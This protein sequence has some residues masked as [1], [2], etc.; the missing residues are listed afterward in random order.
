M[1]LTLIIARPSRNCTSKLHTRPLV[2]EGAPQEDNHKCPTVIK[3]WSW[4]PGG[5]LISRQIIHL[6]VVVVVVVVVAAAAVRGDRGNP[7]PEG[8]TDLPCSEGI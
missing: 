8:V 2:I 6:V 7:V 4:V 1:T 5:C 3:I